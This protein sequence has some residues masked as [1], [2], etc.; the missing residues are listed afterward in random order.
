VLVN[1]LQN[2]I[3]LC[4]IGHLLQLVVERNAE[5]SS[6]FF[7]RHI[8]VPYILRVSIAV[9]NRFK[10]SEWHDRRFARN[11]DHTVS[12]RRR[13]HLQLRVQ[14]IL[15][16]LC[17][18]MVG[19]PGKAVHIRFGHFR[20]SGQDALLQTRHQLFCNL[21]TL[22]ILRGADNGVFAHSVFC[23]DSVAG[24]GAVDQVRI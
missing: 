4:I 5:T 20:L 17:P 21:H 19:R 18:V 24:F 9:V 3:T 1:D 2:H 14:N 16:S 13:F 11:A 23:C 22:H 7:Q 8:L 10:L 15:Q 12:V 6:E